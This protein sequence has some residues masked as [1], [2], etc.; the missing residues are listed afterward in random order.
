MSN[1][2]SHPWSFDLGALRKALQSA[3]EHKSEPVLEELHKALG[4]LLNAAVKSQNNECA[5]F[6]IHAGA[7]VDYEHENFRDSESA[8]RG[9]AAEMYFQF[10][11]PVPSEFDI[12]SALIQQPGQCKIC[13]QHLREDPTIPAI[14]FIYRHTARTAHSPLMLAI[15]NKDIAAIQLL[16]KQGAQPNYDCGVWEDIEHITPWRFVILKDF[17][18]ALTAFIKNGLDINQVFDTEWVAR[19]TDKCLGVLLKSGLHHKKLSASSL[20]AI[21]A[22]GDGPMVPPSH[23]EEHPF[24]LKFA[25]CLTVRQALLQGDPRNLFVTATQQNLSLPRSL[26]EYLV[27]DVDLR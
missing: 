24:S 3:V 1:K 13:A 23:E 20:L 16:L 5:E 4:K 2:D 11:Y 7:D 27:C 19:C 22:G 21:A 8:F 9:Y 26:C 10:G 17:G 15:E 25:C 6:L 14:D 18:S 12:I